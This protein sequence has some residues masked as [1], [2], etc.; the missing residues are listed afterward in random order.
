MH[1]KRHLLG[2]LAPF[3]LLAGLPALAAPPA[4][5][6]YTVGVCDANFPQRCEQSGP[7]IP[8]SANTATLAVTTSTGRVALPGTGPTVILTN[9]G[10]TDLALKL[11]GSTV[12]AATTDFL[13]PSGRSTVFA[14]Q[15]NTYVAAITASS[16]SSLVAQTGSGTPNFSG[17]GGSVGGAITVAD[18]ADVAEGS[19]TDAACAGD[20]TSGC[21]I[22]QRIQRVSQRITSLIAA[23]G[24][25]LQSG[26]TVGIA[27]QFT[28]GAISCLHVVNYTSAGVELDPAS[29]I[30]CGPTTTFVPCPT[31]AGQALQATAA[32]QATLD[33]AGAAIVPQAGTSQRT[34]TAT[35]LSANTSTTICP[36]AT[37]P[38]ATEIYFTTAL[39]G[40][41]LNGQTLTTATPGTTTTNSPD[42]VVN[43]AGTLY[44]APVGVSNAITAYGAAGVVRCVQTLR[45]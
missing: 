8:D 43:T 22:E 36:T 35:N 19:T 13:L 20:A 26:G 38:V 10:S 32:K 21:T 1:I 18:G 37:N 5:I 42:F 24:S 4:N 33:A 28:C 41:G 9:N 45:Q 17:G 31:L 11:G 16:T 25:P 2:W 6:S 14:R 29:P 30:N 12:T 39:V 15:T 7:F 40:V 27:S 44:T 3:A 23:I 34:L